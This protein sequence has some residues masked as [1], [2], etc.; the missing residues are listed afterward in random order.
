MKATLKA[1]KGNAEMF[2]G[3]SY[4]P[5]S[6]DGF[7]FENYEEWKEWCA[8]ALL[9]AK[10]CENY[11]DVETQLWIATNHLIKESLPD[12]SKTHQEMKKMWNE[13]APQKSKTIGIRLP[14]ELITALKAD[15]DKLNTVVVERLQNSLADERAAKLDIKGL[16]TPGE[17]SA[18]AASLNGTLIDDTMIYSREMLIA[19][20]EDAEQYEG[21]L[22]QF[23]A[24]DLCA[25]LTKLTRLQVAAVLRR[26]SDFWK[27]SD[28]M[29]LE[30]WA[31]Y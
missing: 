21:T 12:N 3:N 14:S 19:N 30:V 1:Y 6:W 17:W 27:N 9:P 15:G 18:L 26:V 24:A 20:C 10:E 11:E 7:E 22:S 28:K 13:A 16:F 5:I 4:Y 2:V 31:K 25:K 23:G 8:S 29:A